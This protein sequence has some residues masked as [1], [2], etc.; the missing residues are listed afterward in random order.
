[1][2]KSGSCKENVLGSFFV[3]EIGRLSKLGTAVG[4]A[5]DRKVEEPAE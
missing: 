2:S 1:M 4:F 5:R 3:A